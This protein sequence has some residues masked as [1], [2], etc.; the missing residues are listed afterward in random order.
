VAN[1]TKTLINRRDKAMAAAEKAVSAYNETIDALI[2]ELSS[3][4]GEI[5]ELHEDAEAAA[6][7]ADATLEEI[8]EYCFKK[9]AAAE[10]KGDDDEADAW[11]IIAE[12]H[13][14]DCHLTPLEPAEL[15]DDMSGADLSCIV[16][17]FA[18]EA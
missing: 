1:L 6:E 7:K 8:R 5:N 15:G 12:S 14:I 18:D 17:D 9:Q 13:D 10:N 3:M 4:Q 16:T 2:D 11:A